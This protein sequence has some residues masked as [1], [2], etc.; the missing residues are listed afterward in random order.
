M[1]RHSTRC[2]LSLRETVAPVLLTALLQDLVALVND[3]ELELLEAHALLCHQLWT[4]TEGSGGT[5]QQ[6]GR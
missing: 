4:T 6:Q 3:E 5:Q 1:S 2:A